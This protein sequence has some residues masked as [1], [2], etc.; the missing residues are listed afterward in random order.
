VIT[1]TLDVS[2]IS[3]GSLS[4]GDLIDLSECTGIDVDDMQRLIAGGGRG[5][6]R[7]RLLVGMA[8][9]VARR[10]TP[11]LTYA[12]VLAGQVEVTG[13]ADPKASRQTRARR[14]A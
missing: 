5:A 13:T 9:I 7:L 3:A 14:S 8:W 1:Y 6:N 4:F 12:D 10:D 2:Q 11:E